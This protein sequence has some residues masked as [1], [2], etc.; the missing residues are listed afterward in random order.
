M[1]WKHWLPGRETWIYYL[2][3]GL[4]F[5]RIFIPPQ[6]QTTQY[7]ESLIERRANTMMP[8]LP[9]SIS[10]KAYSYVRDSVRR[11]VLMENAT[12]TNKGTSWGVFNMGTA[13]YK[14]NGKYYFFMEGYELPLGFEYY[15]ENGKNYLEWL[16]SLRD[17]TRRKTE[18]EAK[19]LAADNNEQA[20]VLLPVTKK[21]TVV[22]SV[23]LALLSVIV[24]IF[25]LFCFIGLPFRIL[26][27]ISKREVF[28]LENIE[29]F[30]LIARFLFV[31]AAVSILLPVILNLVLKSKIP[32]AVH[33]S[34]YNIVMENVFTI[35]GGL[36]AL[37]FGK[38]FRRGYELEKEH[39]LTI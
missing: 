16:T 17:I 27:N 15:T 36:V 11:A 21:T 18:T 7:T 4:F 28:K 14:E 2:I 31:F 38:A 34:Y 24:L 12:N 32:E 20:I 23:I 39:E 37:E 6:H 3:V 10:W 25:S 33:L 35:I 13:S 29:A 8:V 1:Y 19:I 26:K 5:L 30:H 22:V 9:D